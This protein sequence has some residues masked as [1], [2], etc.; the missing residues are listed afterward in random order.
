MREYAQGATLQDWEA[1]RDKQKW[2]SLAGA[3]NNPSHRHA[4]KGDY[5]TA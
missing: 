5:I 1:H 3:R 2:G 4:T